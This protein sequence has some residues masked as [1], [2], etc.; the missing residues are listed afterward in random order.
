MPNTAVARPQ[1]SPD[2]PDHISHLAIA[3]Y[4]KNLSLDTTH[5]PV[6]HSLLLA[7]AG[8]TH[9]AALPLMLF[10]QLFQDMFAAYT[11]V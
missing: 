8:P 9:P 6:R 5:R 10:E 3:R 7:T 2:A 4:A 1:P 11:A